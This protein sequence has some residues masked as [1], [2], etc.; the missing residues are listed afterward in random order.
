MCFISPQVVHKA[1][2]NVDE[3]GSEAA[4]A[5]AVEIMLLSFP[6]RI[7]FNSPFLM[8]IFDRVTNSTLFIGKIMNPNE[9]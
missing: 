4:A 9:K 8:L 1:M 6:P 3:R 7:E 5:T 2:V